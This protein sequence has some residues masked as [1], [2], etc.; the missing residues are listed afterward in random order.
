MRAE[1]QRAAPTRTKRT[2]DQPNAHAHNPRHTLHTA[3]PPTSTHPHPHPHTT[4]APS[5]LGLTVGAVQS[6]MPPSKAREAYSCDVT[7]VTGQQLCF[8]YLNDH[9]ARS[10]GEL[11]SGLSLVACRL[12]LLLDAGCVICECVWMWMCVDVMR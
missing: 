12:L 2:S 1:E 8:N 3:H 6:D 7:Y 10:T 11:V 4:N 9:T 5:F